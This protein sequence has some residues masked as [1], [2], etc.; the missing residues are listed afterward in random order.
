[1]YDA[2]LSFVAIL[3]IGIFTLCA[4]FYD[5][6]NKP[7]LLV[8]SF[9]GFRYD[10]INKNVTPTLLSLHGKGVHSQY[11]RNVFIT[12]TFPNHH[13][14]ATGLFPSSHGVMASSVYDERYGKVI[15]YS[16]ELWKFGNSVTP[17]WAN[18][19]MYTVL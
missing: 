4:V 13:S 11:M 10:Y 6:P 17:L 14:I 15:S 1:M 18:L 2:V 19:K 12:K 5:S 7:L 9:D 3:L 16:E 8:V